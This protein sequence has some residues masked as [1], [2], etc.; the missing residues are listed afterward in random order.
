MSDQINDMR[1][2]I[3][4][5]RDLVQS[6]SG[7][8][9]EIRA[10]VENHQETSTRLPKIE[11]RVAV[12]EAQVAVI[13]GIRLEDK[14]GRRAASASSAVWIGLAVSSLIALLGIV[15]SVILALR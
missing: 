3:H 13:Q 7:D 11:S 9:R 12:L 1:T 15:A 6:L 5:I 4:Q 8:I 2:E 14:A 10:R